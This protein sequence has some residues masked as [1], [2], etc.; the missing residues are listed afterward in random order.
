MVELA[1]FIEW[2]TFPFLRGQRA[3]VPN[4]PGEITNSQRC[5]LTV[6]VRMERAFLPFFGLGPFC[7]SPTTSKGD[8]I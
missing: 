8:R 6:S 2:K 5:T 1:C 3:S 7:I 4:A